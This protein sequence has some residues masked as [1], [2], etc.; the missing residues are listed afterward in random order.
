MAEEKKS[1]SIYEHHFRDTMVMLVVL[2]LLGVLV[3]RIRVVWTSESLLYSSSEELVAWFKSNMPIW[4][5]FAILFS[6]LGIGLTVYNLMGRRGVAKAEE[7][8]YGAYPADEFLEATE[9]VEKGDKRWT[10]VI[11]L[12]N[13]DQS[14]DWKLAIIES[15]IILEAL[16]KANSYDGE[17]VGEM[18]KQVEPSDMLTLD[19]AWEAHKVRNR[20]AHAGSNFELSEREAKRVVALFESVFREYQII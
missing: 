20:I 3:Q 13:S 11:E 7:L 2:L 19:N 18:L 17:G 4:R 6:S 8:V 9:E 14:S 12:I 15:D 1:V 5:I 10:R 16:L